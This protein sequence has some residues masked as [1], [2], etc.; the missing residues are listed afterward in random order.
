MATNFT[1]NYTHFIISFHYYH[2][3]RFICD[4][5]HI[6]KLEDTGH[7]SIQLTFIVQLV[8]KSFCLPH[9][10]LV[11]PTD[12]LRLFTEAHVGWQ[13]IDITVVNNPLIVVGWLLMY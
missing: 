9:I 12:N 10:A 5:V 11:I 2:S 13:P 1:H 7:C 4:A 6:E 3:Y 8:N